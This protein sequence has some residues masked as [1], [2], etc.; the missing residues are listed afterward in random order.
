MRGRP[1]LTPLAQKAGFT[2]AGVGQPAGPG[3]R[4]ELR[5]DA[6]R[7]RFPEHGRRTL[8]RAVASRTARKKKNDGHR[9]GR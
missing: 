9:S 2:P 6:I 5:P 4:L 3:R 7:G 1:E 8:T